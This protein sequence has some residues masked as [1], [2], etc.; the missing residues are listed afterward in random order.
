MRKLA[1]SLTSA[2]ILCTLAGAASADL[3]CWIEPDGCRRCVYDP[4]YYNPI[5][6][7]RV[8]P[9]QAKADAEWQRQQAIEELKDRAYEGD[10]NAQLMLKI[11]RE[12]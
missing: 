1:V 2:L 3:R 4:A 8:P 7:T 5:L 10:R 9:E 6:D 12:Q 11:L